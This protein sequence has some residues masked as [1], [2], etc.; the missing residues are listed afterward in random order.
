M[1][2]LDRLQ[3]A[4]KA[5]TT[6]QQELNKIQGRIESLTDSLEKACGSRDVKEAQGMVEK[7]DQEVHEKETQ[8]DAL[9]TKIEQV[10]NG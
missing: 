5:L 7:W 2:L 1:N 4:E 3:K 6:A 10:V 9:L 8:L